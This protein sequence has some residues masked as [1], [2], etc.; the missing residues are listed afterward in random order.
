MKREFKTSDISMEFEIE[1]GSLVA[2]VK[3]LDQDVFRPLAIEDKTKMSWFVHSLSN[4]IMALFSDQ[5][6]KGVMRVAPKPPIV[7]KREE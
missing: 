6:Y 2:N 4:T 7:A 5:K 3:I 1:E